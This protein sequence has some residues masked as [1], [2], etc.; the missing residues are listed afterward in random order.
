M[1]AS[2]TS[3][4]NG[5]EVLAWANVEMPTCFGFEVPVI[6]GF[7][8]P[9]IAGFDASGTSGRVQEYW[10]ERLHKLATSVGCWLHDVA[11][12]EA[13]R[14]CSDDGCTKLQRWWLHNVAAMMV[15]RAG[16]A[17]G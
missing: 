12:L 9:V 7:G 5:V 2:N 16:N 11:T 10:R 17:G 6:A 15:A 4:Y 14:C 1:D 13:A 3:K 8:V